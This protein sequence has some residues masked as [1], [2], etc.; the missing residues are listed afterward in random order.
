MDPIELS[1]SEFD[2]WRRV[3][4]DT[5]GIAGTLSTLPGE[6]DLNVAVD[7]S[8]VDLSHDGQIVKSLHKLG[9]ARRTSLHSRPKLGHQQLRCAGGGQGQHSVLGANVQQLRWIHELQPPQSPPTGT[10]AGESPAHSAIGFEFGG[11]E[12]PAPARF[13]PPATTGAASLVVPQR[14]PRRIPHD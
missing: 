10:D 1:S 2:R 4:G 11:H 3:L 5:W 8:L 14:A 13:H 12:I 6:L 7:G 9:R